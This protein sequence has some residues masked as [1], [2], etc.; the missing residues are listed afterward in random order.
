MTELPSSF[1]QLQTLRE[2]YLTGNCLSDLPESFCNLSKLQVGVTSK[3]EGV[4][5]DVV[6]VKKKPLNR[7]KQKQHALAMF[8]PLFHVG[9]FEHVVKTPP[10]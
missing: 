3:L 9:L 5:M 4:T 10:I 2:L 1:G 6:A 7:T 8:H